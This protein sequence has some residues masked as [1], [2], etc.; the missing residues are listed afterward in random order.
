M[1]HPTEHSTRQQVSST[2][3]S[4]G[5]P[6]PAVLLTSAPVHPGC[7]GGP[8]INTADGKLIG[9][10]TSFLYESSVF[11][12]FG[13]GKRSELHPMHTLLFPVSMGCPSSATL[14]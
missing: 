3:A 1:S 5:G 8:V 9:I 6:V 13:F 14:Q 2:P 4:V 11:D 10:M 7:S 12:H